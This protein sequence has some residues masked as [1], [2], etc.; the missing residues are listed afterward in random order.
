VLNESTLVTLKM[1][2]YILCSRCK[3]SSL[4]LVDVIKRFLM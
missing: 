4:I 3:V 1:F 2:S